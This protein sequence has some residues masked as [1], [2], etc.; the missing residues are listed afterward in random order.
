MSAWTPTI[1]SVPARPRP[2]WRLVRGPARWRA[3]AST[4]GERPTSRVNIKKLGAKEVFLFGLVGSDPYAG[5]LKSLL[6]KAGVSE[7]LV[8][9]D[10]AWSTQVYN[11]IYEEGLEDPRL[12][13]GN[14]NEP[15]VESVEAIVQ[16]MERS[17]SSCDAVIIN[18]QAAGSFQTELF[19]KRIG[20]FMGAKRGGIWICDCR[21]LNDAYDGAIRKLNDREAAAIYA[22]QRSRGE[23]AEPSAEELIAWLFKRW[24]APLVLTRGADGALAYD[25]EGPRRYSGAPHHRPDR[26]GRRGR[27]L[28]R[29]SGRLPRRGRGYRHRGP[30]RQ[31]LRGS[32][33]PEALPDRPSRSRRDRGHS[34][35]AGL[36]V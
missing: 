8:V 13:I 1:L 23:S 10:R 35:V 20:A 36:S 21:T 30:G 18:E 33:G 4:S 7:R 11:K 2:R 16:A 9:Q 5:I 28:P 19:R 26:S 12:D 27:R 25:R 6:A 17:L 15:S 29:G 32:V 31:L 3:S 34:P 22:G 24:R 14:F